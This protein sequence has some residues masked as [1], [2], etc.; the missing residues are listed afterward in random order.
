MFVR[1]L[2]YSTITGSVLLV[3]GLAT[4]TAQASAA[5]APTA[6][7]PAVVAGDNWEFVGNYYWESDCNNA[8][9]GMVSRHEVVKYRCDDGS[10]FPGDDYDLEVVW[11]A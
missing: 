6:P 2:V 1:K 7:A 9:Q 3:G 11:P 8:G 5:P 10:W 4:T